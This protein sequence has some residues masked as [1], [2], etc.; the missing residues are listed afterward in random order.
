MAPYLT[1][2]QIEDRLDGRFGIST[3]ITDG[4]AEIAT[5]EL[6]ALAPFIGSKLDSEQERAF[7]RT[8]NPDGTTNE[9]ED[10]P[11]AVL[12][13]VA[14]CAYTMSAEETPGI[15]SES[16]GS[17]SRSYAT[18]KTN[19]TSRRMSVLVEP[20]LLKVGQRLTG[21]STWRTHESYPDAPL[22]IW[23]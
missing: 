23:G 16:I 10:P 21:S 2:A 6:E 11:D 22:D 20:Y 1:A 9:D 14:L 19:Q 17:T 8:I 15:T 18:P 3:T 12:D 7:P 4:D 13:W 5:Y